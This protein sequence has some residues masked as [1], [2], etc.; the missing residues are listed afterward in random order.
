[1]PKINQ[2]EEKKIYSVSVADL[3]PLM[4]RLKHVGRLWWC[5][6]MRARYSESDRDRPETRC[7]V[8]GWFPMN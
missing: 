1:M 3:S 4:A 8:K 6:F 5:Q 2:I 7:S